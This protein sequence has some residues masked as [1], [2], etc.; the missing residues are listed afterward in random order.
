MTL[1]AVA[2]PS[3]GL[4][5]GAER[6]GFTDFLWNLRNPPPDRPGDAPQLRHWM[7]SEE[8]LDAADVMRL[9][10]EFPKP[11]GIVVPMPDRRMR[12][13]ALSRNFEL[14]A[15]DEFP[16]W[17]AGA[18]LPEQWR[19]AGDRAGAILNESREILLAAAARDG[20]ETALR[21]F[22]GNPSA[23]LLQRFELRWL[24]APETAEA[25]APTH[26][27]GQLAEQ[28]QDRRTALATAAVW[29][30]RGTCN[31]AWILEWLHALA[32]DLGRLRLT[33]LQLRRAMGATDATECELAELA[34]VLTLKSRS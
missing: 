18:Q 11:A 13:L 14:F 33:Q 25:E 16:V 32:D 6:A 29:L 5:R 2:C 17:R 34:A 31:H 19:N 8:P 9:L 22:F 27:L 10:P 3:P 12:D 21:N 1:R 23:E 30:A 28:Y 7:W 26:R 24:A 4:R 15:T 20:R